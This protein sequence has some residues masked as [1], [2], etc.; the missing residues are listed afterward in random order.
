M[1]VTLLKD[2]QKYVI[3]STIKKEQIELVKKYRPNAL[4]VKDAENKNDIFAMS[5][6]EGKSCVGANSITFG[7]ANDAG[8]LI[9]TGDIPNGLNKTEAKE[10]LAD[11]VG[12]VQAHVKTIEDKFDT[13]VEEIEASRK[14][15]VDSIVEA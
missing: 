5:Y 14:T 9:A 12:A 7:S 10:W 13:L 3:T 2:V 6:L 1:K 15:I 8:N 4:K 11:K